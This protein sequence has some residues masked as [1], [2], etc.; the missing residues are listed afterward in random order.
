MTPSLKKVFTDYNFETDN[1]DIVD[2][3]SR[4][5]VL[6][7]TSLQY[8]RR[9]DLE[10][11]GLSTVWIQLQHPGRK[12]LLIHS[13][14]RQFQRLGR[15]GTLN[16]ASQQSRWAKII[17][18]WEQA[19]AEG[20]EII[21]MGDLNLNYLCWEVQPEGMNSYDRIKKQMIDL[22]K[23]KI[24]MTGHMI[25][26]NTPTKISNNPDIPDSCLD[27]MITNRKEKIASYQAGLP[28]F[29]DH[30]MQIL[31]RS[32]K[33]IISNK[34]YIRT[35]SFKNF[36]IQQYKINIKDHHQYI[37]VMYKRDPEIITKKIQQIIQDS[38]QEISPVITIQTATRS[39]TQLSEKIRYMM[40]E[41]D[42]AHSRYIQSR[43]AEDFR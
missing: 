26:T 18:K 29:S 42:Q 8:K 4:T 13:I 35:R 21:T 38:L 10:V 31:I 14:Y 3:M 39:R 24:L 5:G 23:E 33:P 15:P 20:K 12:P 11:T 36:N 19:T 28:T 25:L 32:C 22:I 34:I 6:V 2:K 30:T 9:R 40:V 1:L 16:P 43:K 7:H 27:L 37:E 17:D 41:R